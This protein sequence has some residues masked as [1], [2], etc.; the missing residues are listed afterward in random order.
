MKL[1]QTLEPKSYVICEYEKEYCC[2]SAASGRIDISRSRDH[3]Y[4]DIITE[5]DLSF[6]FCPYC[7][8]RIEIINI[9]PTKDKVKDAIVKLI[10]DCGYKPKDFNFNPFESK[11]DILDNI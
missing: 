8:A 11:Y 2:E 1:I 6:K 7:G 3:I 10:K 4:K 5:N 9:S